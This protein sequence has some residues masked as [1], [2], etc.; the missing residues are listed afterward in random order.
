[1]T[2]RGL[3]YMYHPI[4]SIVLHQYLLD[5]LLLPKSLLSVIKRPE[6]VELESQALVR[7]WSC[8]LT[9]VSNWRSVVAIVPQVE[10]L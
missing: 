10:S 3:D 8:L 1:M 9:L 5:Y 6:S 7:V 4:S 2:S